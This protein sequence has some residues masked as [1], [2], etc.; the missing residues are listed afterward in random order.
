VDEAARSNRGGG[1]R[2]VERSRPDAPS[3]DRNP[4]PAD[5][6]PRS[7]DRDPPSLDRDPHPV[8]RKIC[9][10]PVR[11]VCVDARIARLAAAQHGV[12]HLRQLELLGLCPRAVQKR[13]QAFRLHRVHRGVYSLVP[14]TLLTR[15]G[16]YMAAV[17]ACG[18]GAVLS[19]RSAAALAELR[20]DNRSRIDVAVPRRGLRRRDIDI[21][22]TDTL[23]PD[24]VTRIDGIPCTSVARTLVD[25][26]QVVSRR[27]L[28]RTFD[29][30]EVLG[31][32]NLRGVT[33]QLA[34]LGRRRG[35]ARVRAVLETHHAGATATWSEL[36]EAFL[37]LVRAARLPAPEVNAWLM[38]DDGDP[39]I[40]V[41]FLWREQRV[42]LETDGWNT[43][44]TRQSFEHDRRIDQR[45]TAARFTPVRA[46]WRQ[47]KCERRRLA[48]TLR[49]VLP[50]APAQ[51][52]RG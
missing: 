39:P 8:D 5:R 17:L 33:Q 15:N 42:V 41:D 25:I 4:R 36:E 11:K 12:F 31:V 16:R 45:L 23:A 7:L 21:H 44:K 18:P 1:G 6:D 47:I 19:H 50:R 24:D 3:V 27:A 37:E 28:E 43:H 52:S 51:A 34:R 13:A 35:V 48:Q 14:A 29:Q 22:R 26:A 46:T 32:L 49:R 10:P 2:R 40:R 38:L 9:E 20:A 30:A